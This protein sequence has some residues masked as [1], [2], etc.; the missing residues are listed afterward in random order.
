VVERDLVLSVKPLV[1]A[2][3]TFRVADE[4]LE[5]VGDRSSKFQ[6]AIKPI[7]N[8]TFLVP[9]PSRF[10]SLVLGF[11]CEYISK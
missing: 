9:V 2:V 6:S 8:K 4:F 7:P 5:V 1:V 11:E 10:P 3:N